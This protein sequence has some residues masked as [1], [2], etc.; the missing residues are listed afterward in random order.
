M[1]LGAIKSHIHERKYIYTPYAKTDFSRRYEEGS[2]PPPILPTFSG[3]IL[4]ITVIFTSFL[5]K[6]K[7]AKI[8]FQFI[9]YKEKTSFK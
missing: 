4:I 7:N 3:L 2:P 6:I 1:P 9:L 5:P 8:G